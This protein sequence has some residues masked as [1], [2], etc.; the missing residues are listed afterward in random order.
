M[1]TLPQILAA[2]LSLSHPTNYL[3]TVPFT[4]NIVGVGIGEHFD[5]KVPRL[6]DNSFLSEAYNERGVVCEW[7]SDDAVTNRTPSSFQSFTGYDTNSIP[8]RFKFGDISLF[9]YYG[10][11]SS[12]FSNPSNSCQ[13][14]VSFTSQTVNEIVVITNASL[15]SDPSAALPSMFVGRVPIADRH[16]SRN[17]TN[18]HDLLTHVMTAAP[19]TNAYHDI[20]FNNALTWHQFCRETNG[21]KTSVNSRRQYSKWPVRFDDDGNVVYATNENTRTEYG[22]GGRYSVLVPSYFL[23]EQ[24]VKCGFSM[25]YEGRHVGSEHGE[26]ISATETTQTPSNSCCVTF[27]NPLGKA[28]IESVKLFAVALFSTSGSRYSNSRSETLYSRSASLLVPLVPSDVYTTEDGLYSVDFSI[29]MSSIRSDVMSKLGESLPLPN[30]V[31][32]WIDDPPIPGRSSEGTTIF[33]GD[34][35]TAMASVNLMI[36]HIVGIAKMKYNARIVD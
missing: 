21:N 23:T 9:N 34:S 7:L 17:F 36:R 18:D 3:F 27:S 16:F 8:H 10:I 6:E 1:T 12:A 29:D 2:T 13:M 19:Y 4:T 28:E 26:R 14:A 11:L 30:D 24:S 31:S 25:Y 32:S 33:S 20:A 35:N 5:Y 15:Y 22:G